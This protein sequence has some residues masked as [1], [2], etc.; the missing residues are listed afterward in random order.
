MYHIVFW[1]LYTTLKAH[2][3]SVV[4]LW[5]YAKILHY[6]WLHSLCRGA[7]LSSQHVCPSLPP[8]WHYSGPDTECVF[9]YLDTHTH[10]HIWTPSS[11]E[12]PC[13][14]AAD[15]T[16]D[17]EEHKPLLKN[18]ACQCT[19]LS[20]IPTLSAFLP[21]IFLLLSFHCSTF[22]MHNDFIPF[23]VCLPTIL[24]AMVPFFNS[25]SL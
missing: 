17:F 21:A 4:M 23:V 7:F 19:R 6:Y 25:I 2:T 9:P 18:T 12:R 3:V 22:Q 1:Q 13:L 24:A 14:E 15:F 20:F 11:N 16:E 5:H 8:S 10:L